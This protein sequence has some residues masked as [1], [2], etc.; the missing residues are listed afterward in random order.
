M[1]PHYVAF[2]LLA[3][4][5]VIAEDSLGLYALAV[6]GLPL[7]MLWVAEKQYLDRSRATVTELRMSNDELEAANARLFRL[8][9]E[10]RQLLG[11]MQRSYLSTITSLARTVEA[12]DPYTGGHTERVAEIAVLLARELGFD[13]TELPAIN[14]GAIIHDI[15]KVGTPDQILLQA[16]RPRRRRRCARYGSTPR[17]RATSSPSSSCRRWSSR[18]CAA[19]TSASTATAIRTG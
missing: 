5:F 7:L 6:F 1:V 8:L 13:E 17:W 14:V 9:D 19:T 4:T 3:G 2:G 16:G 12:K 11:R 10:N 18:W 15:G